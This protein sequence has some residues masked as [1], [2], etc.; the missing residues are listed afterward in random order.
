MI[1]QHDYKRAV[2]R[3]KLILK[4][5]RIPIPY[6]AEIEVADFGLN[7]LDEIGLEILV[8]VNDVY[9]GKWLV[10]FKNQQC[11]EHL[12]PL[13]Q[14]TFVCHYGS[15]LL[16]VDGKQILLKPGEQYTIP[17]KTKHWFKATEGDAVV[18]EISTT[19]DDASDIFTDPNID[20]ITKVKS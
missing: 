10:L 12:H 3:T 2:D 8:L 7:E 20:R 18:L 19:S 14:E 1:S 15:V 6:E 4:E 17:P 11:P 9:C 16:D 13:K 5:A